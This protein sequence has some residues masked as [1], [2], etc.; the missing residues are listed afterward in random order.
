[1]VFKNPD[2]RAGYREMMDAK[3]HFRGGDYPGPEGGAGA[4]G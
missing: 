4:G 3:E 1:M 2:I